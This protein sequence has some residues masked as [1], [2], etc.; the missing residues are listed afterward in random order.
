[1]QTLI[2]R[3][4][5]HPLQHQATN[6]WYNIRRSP[7]GPEVLASSI[8][9]YEWKTISHPFDSDIHP[10]NINHNSWTPKRTVQGQELEHFQ[11]WVNASRKINLNTPPWKSKKIIWINPISV[12]VRFVNLLGG[13]KTPENATKQRPVAGCLFGCQNAAKSSRGRGRRPQADNLMVAR[14]YPKDSHRIK[15][16]NSWFP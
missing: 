11:A 9:G 1:M 16:G 8:V 3:Q 14:V 13:K 2:L 12:Q 7:T 6:D 10:F 15:G 4:R 5:F